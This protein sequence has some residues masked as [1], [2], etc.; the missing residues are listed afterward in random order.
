VGSVPNAICYF[1][2]VL[3]FIFVCILMSALSFIMLM[4]FIGVLMIPGGLGPVSSYIY[5]QN[6][7]CH[8]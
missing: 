4:G 3:I 5:L 6:I 1:N 2:N 8:Y 7:S